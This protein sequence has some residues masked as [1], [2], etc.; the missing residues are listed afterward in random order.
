MVSA[1]TSFTSRPGGNRTEL[2]DVISGSKP[3]KIAPTASAKDALVSMIENKTD[4]LLVDRANT[5]DAYGIIT[6]WDLVACAVADAKDLGNT[7]I[8]ELARKPLV[9]TNNLDLNI[10]WVARKMVNEGVSKLAVFD[11]EEFVGFVSDV[12]ILR[13]VVSK[14]KPGKGAKE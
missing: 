11:K 10:K 7:P 5:N 4:Y 13:A 6:K 1:M 2:R 3:V 8:L 14:A 12:D 9:V